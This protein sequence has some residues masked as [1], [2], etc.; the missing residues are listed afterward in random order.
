M[1][2]PV[3]RTM[4]HLFTSTATHGCHSETL[5]PVILEFGFRVVGFGVVV[6][7]PW[8]PEMG[9]LSPQVHT[10]VGLGEGDGDG[11]GEGVGGVVVDPTVR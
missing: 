3:Q 10:S 9:F 1:R 8:L 2:V 7:W 5:P 6:C 4:S 11:E